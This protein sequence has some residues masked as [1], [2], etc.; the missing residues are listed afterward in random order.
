[1]SKHQPNDFSDFKIGEIYP[2][3]LIRIE[4]NIYKYAGESCVNFSCTACNSGIIYRGRVDS[5]R[6]HRTIRCQACGRRSKR[7]EGFTDDWKSKGIRTKENVQNKHLT[8]K[9]IGEVHGDWFVNAFSHTTNTGHGHSYYICININTGKT[10]TC[11]L[12]HLPHNIDN[13]ISNIATIDST[14]IPDTIKTTNSFGESSVATWLTNHNIDFERE[15]QFPDLTGSGGGLLRFDFKILNQPIL[16]EFQ[17]E[18]HYHPIKFFGGQ[19]QFEKQQI[20]DN[21][22]RNYCKYHNYTLIEIPYNYDTIDTYLNVL[23][24]IK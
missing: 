24:T 5:I 16:I 18:Q 23:L 20:H 21:L 6:A 1:M 12:D 11:R 4:S 15:Y 17:G 3:S 9:R 7:P 19:T 10:K 14:Q 13:T 22:K 2:G 8:N